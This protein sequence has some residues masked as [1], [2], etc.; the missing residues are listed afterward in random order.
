VNVLDKMG[1]LK[2]SVFILSLQCA[3][4]CLDV[5]LNLL[6]KTVVYFSPVALDTVAVV[7]GHRS[8]F[9]EAIPL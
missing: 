5:S 1:L 6:R 9:W 3:C 4:V 7:H 8:G 2:Y